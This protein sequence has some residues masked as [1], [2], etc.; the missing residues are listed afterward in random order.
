MRGPHNLFRLVRAG[1]TFERTGAMSD[2]LEKLNAPLS[3]RVVLRA[4][5]W[6]FS[7][8]GLKGES[9]LPPVPRALTAL[10]PVYIKLG[11]NLSTRP[12]L[13]GT[14]LSAD[15]R[16][17]LDKLPPFS[18]EDAKRI[19][20]YELGTDVDDLFTEFSDPVA[21][22]S[23][24]Q[25]HR[26]RLRSSGEEVAVKILRPGI[27][28]VVQRDIDAL[29]LTARFIEFL[30]PATRR[31][32]PTAVIAHFEKNTLAEIDLRMEASAISEFAVNTAD[33]EGFS[34]PSLVWELSAKRV[35]TIGWAVG[36]PLSDPAALSEHGVDLDAIATRLIQSFIRHALRD[37]FFH[38]DLHQG[39]LMITPEGSLLA[40]DFGITGRIDDYTRRVYAEILYGF[41]QRDY[42]R[43]A[44]VHFEAGYVPRNQDMKAF[45]QALRS[46]GEPIFG[47]DATHISMGPLLRH[48]FDVTERFGM[49]TRTELLLLQKTMVVVEGVARSLNPHLNMWEAAQPVVE[50]Y[51]KDNVGPKAIIR[52]AARTLETIARFGPRVPQLIEDSLNRASEGSHD[53]QYAKPR[54]KSNLVWFLIGV[55]VTVSVMLMADLI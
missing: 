18:N 26:A 54:K 9:D 25:V 22:A 23:I 42:D 5:V 35:L 21:A 24:A 38:A 8:L 11:Q 29:Y 10:G 44:R 16:I 33:D 48:L 53:D 31:L 6:P 45:S 43:V 47:Q 39:N 51:I 20:K 46:V 17:L 7:W 15:L 28:R 2:V 49:E 41:I 13:V 34:V 1:A 50:Q 37:G 52:D 40:I 19:I 27:E 55:A 14:D 30:V 36:V 4:M 32:H 12:D 3:F